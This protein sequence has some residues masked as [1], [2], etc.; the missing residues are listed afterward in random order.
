MEFKFKHMETGE[1]KSIFLTAQ[2]IQDRLAFELKDELTCDCEP[3]G[4]TNVIECGCYDYFDGFELLMH[5]V[6]DA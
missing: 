3:I 6:N 1:V 4:E 5:G 2:E